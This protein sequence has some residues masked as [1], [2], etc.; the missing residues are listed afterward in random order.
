MNKQLIIAATAGLISGAAS[1]TAQA[2]LLNPGDLLSIG[3]GSWFAVDMDANRAI[4]AAES[5]SIAPG[6]SGGIV[7]GATQAVGAIDA[8]AWFG[9]PGGH[10]T[11]TAPV[12][13]TTTGI[14]FSGWSIFWDGAPVS[15][16]VD[17]GAWTPVNCDTLGC[18]GVSFANG[19]AAFA[20]SGVYGDSYSL[21]YSWSFQN[22]DP[23]CFCSTD[24]LLHLQGVVTAAAVT[25]VPLPPAVWLFAS[26]LM[27]LLH[28]R[29]RIA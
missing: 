26:G 13:G 20:W 21:W 27:L 6:S 2:A 3:T 15:A 10:Y 11:T 16:V 24:Y 17:Y 18:T 5:V 25:P 19:T 8:W 28:K 1:V 9:A 4:A 12:G 23:G 14:D 7:I 22:A 29:T